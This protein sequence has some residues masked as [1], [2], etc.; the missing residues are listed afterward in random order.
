MNSYTMTANGELTIKC[1]KEKKEAQR[2]KHKKKPVVSFLLLLFLCYRRASA[3]CIPLFTAMTV[4]LSVLTFSAAAYVG[5][6]VLDL[7]LF[8]FFFIRASFK[9]LHTI[10]ATVSNEIMQ[11]VQ[12]NYCML[13]LVPVI[14][15]SSKMITGYDCEQ[16]TFFWGGCILFSISI[17]IGICLLSSTKMF[18]QAL[19]ED[20][21]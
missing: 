16:A 5:L 13:I 2:R 3:L 11:Q 1:K 10:I 19:S 12:T 17:I 20:A 8:V 6:F 7:I 21:A 15:V 4:Q 18:S 9:L 14:C